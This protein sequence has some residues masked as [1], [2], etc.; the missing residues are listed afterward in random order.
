LEYPEAVWVPLTPQ[1]TML[2]DTADG[3]KSLTRT[4]LNTESAI[5]VDRYPQ[6][7]TNITNINYQRTSDDT[8]LDVTFQWIP[9]A[10]G[11]I[12]KFFINIACIMNMTART[13]DGVTFNDVTVSLTKVGG[14]DE[15][16]T[17]VF[18]TGLAQRTTADDADLFIVAHPVLNQS[19]NIRAGNPINIRV[20]ASMTVGATATGHLGICPFFPQQIPA[21]A[22]DVLFWAHS[23]IMFYIS[24]NRR[25]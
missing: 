14:D 20:R 10:T 7:I 2:E 22:A 15:I 16:Y 12:D 13:A 11:R 3:L 1:G 5:P 21:T 4:S 17:Q 18:P 25:T 19:F 23:G 24:R 8:N 9:E 6:T